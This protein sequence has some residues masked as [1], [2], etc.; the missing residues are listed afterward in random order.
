MIYIFVGAIVAIISLIIY[1]VFL[2]SEENKKDDDDDD[3]TETCW[4][5]DDFYSDTQ[6]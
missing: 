3:P 6:I 5:D 1:S 2:P 4:H